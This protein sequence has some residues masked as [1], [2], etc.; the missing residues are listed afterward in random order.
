[1]SPAKG[2]TLKRKKHKKEPYP[3]EDRALK[4]AARF[5]VKELLPLLGVEGTVRRAGPTEA[6][7]LEVKNF[8]ADFVYEMADGTWKRLEFE[9]DRITMEHLRRFRA[10]EAVN[11][12]QYQVE[13][14]TYV[15]CTSNV[16]K[17]K[18][19]LIETMNTYHVSVV[20]MKDCNVDWLMEEVERKQ[21]AGQR[22][23]GEEL[24]KVLLT[25]FMDGELSQTA[26]VKRSLGVLLREQGQ[27]A[28]QEM[29]SMKSVLYTLAMK[30]LPGDELKE[31]REMM[32]LLGQMLMEDE[33][34]KD[35]FKTMKELIREGELT[36]EKAAAR[37]QM[38][39][40]EFRKEFKELRL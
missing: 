14:S 24:L 9:S 7:F 12:Y 29:I 39:V 11:S 40:E 6:V 17:P 15:L 5:M 32:T 37:K 35:E 4:E 8:L 26:R 19:S 2:G 38:T 27:I 30:F 3:L 1:M 36:I 10:C 22:P 23:G 25:P 21:G 20:R 31:I 16:K 13:V 28:K 34:E 33:I 18:S